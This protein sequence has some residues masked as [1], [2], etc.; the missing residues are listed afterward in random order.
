MDEVNSHPRERAS[1][2]RSQPAPLNPSKPDRFLPLRLNKGGVEVRRSGNIFWNGDLVGFIA[3]GCYPIHGWEIYL[4]HKG[5]EFFWARCMDD[6]AFILER[7]FDE[8][9]S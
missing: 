2:A 4:T 1:A 7:E 8:T 3:L 5:V 9:C 6:V